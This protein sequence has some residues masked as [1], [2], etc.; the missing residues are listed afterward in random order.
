MAGSLDH[1]GD[2]TC[3]DA[4]IGLEYELGYRCA[5]RLCG[6]GLPH[7]IAEAPGDRS[8]VIPLQGLEYMLMVTEYAIRSGIDPCFGLSSLE[9]AGP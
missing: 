1:N 5:F 3:P 2:E 4:P 7:E 6:V 9:S 8:F